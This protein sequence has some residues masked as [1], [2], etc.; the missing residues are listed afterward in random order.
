[1][2]AARRASRLAGAAITD[3]DDYCDLVSRTFQPVKVSSTNSQD[4]S[5][6]LSSKTVNGLVFSEVVASEHRVERSPHLVASNRSGLVMFNFQNS[7]VTRFESESGAM[8]LRP[9]DM[10]IYDA[11]APYHIG[12]DDDFRMCVIMCPQEYLGLT[13]SQFRHLAATPMTGESSM[14][15]MVGS[16]LDAVATDLDLLAGRSGTRL[17]HAILDIVTT[18]LHSRLREMGGAAPSSPRSALREAIERKIED[19]LGDAALTP[20]RIADEA[21]ISVR[22]LYGIFQAEGVTVAN[23]IREMRLERCRRDLSD[24]SLAHL[25]IAAIAARWGLTDAPHF[26]R[27]FRARFGTTPSAYRRESSLRGV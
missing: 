26:S 13:D 1:M 24:A 18:A 9:G 20:S 11:D 22:H 2:E 12:A 21:H 27:L 8:T 3:V 23:Y 17:A 14:V 5:A 4:F 19:S 7:G 16:L 10:A 6:R 25:S 15:R